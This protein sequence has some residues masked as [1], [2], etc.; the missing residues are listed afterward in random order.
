MPF[1]CVS[2]DCGYESCRIFVV[3]KNKAN[4]LSVAKICLGEQDRLEETEQGSLK[5]D[6]LNVVGGTVAL[7][8]APTP[9]STVLDICV[10]AVLCHQLL[11]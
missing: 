3:D 5:Y 10:S 6:V 2:T 9:A 7:C 8:K 1:L 4:L 11:A